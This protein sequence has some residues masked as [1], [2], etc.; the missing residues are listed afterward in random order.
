MKIAWSPSDQKITKLKEIVLY[1]AEKSKD[2][3][4]FGATKLNKILFLADFNY[5]AWK[6]ESLTGAKYVHRDKGPCPNEVLSVQDALQIEER[7]TIQEVNYHGYTQKR[8]IP[9]TGADTSIFDDEA[10][11]LVDEVIEKT[12]HANATE[13]SEWTHSLKPWQIT[14]EG[15]EIPLYSIYMLQDRSVGRAGLSWAMQEIKR[16]KEEYGYAP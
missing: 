4:Y 11:S 12:K 6:G 3:P 9:L 2:D 16:L 1:I 8:L 15:E 10:L 14:E 13:I 5:Y 7:A